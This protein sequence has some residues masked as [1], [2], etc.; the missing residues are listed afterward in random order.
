MKGMV[1]RISVQPFE[2]AVALLLIISG[3][4]QFFGWGQS[5]VT[6]IILPRWE[7]HLI[8]SL[9][10]FSGMSVV[11]GV[12]LNLRRFE[13]SGMLFLISMFIIRLMLYA[14]YLGVNWSF[15]ITGVFYISVLWAAVVRV[16][17]ILKGGTIIWIRGDH[18]VGL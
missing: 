2:I 14:V 7:Q 9:A 8:S 17:R 11:A 12:S 3:L 10:I 13:L 1:S 5:D 4:A 18:D 15:A 16:I 6:L